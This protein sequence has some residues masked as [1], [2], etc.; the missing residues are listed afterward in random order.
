MLDERKAAILRAVV[1]EY[2]ETA[3]PVG[4]GAVAKATALTV[5]PATVRNDMA[6]LEADGYLHQPH[7]SA[8]RV[9]T[10][11]G[12]RYFV[13]SV[14]EAALGRPDNRQVMQFFTDMRGEIEDLMRETAGLLS[15]LTDYA[16]VVV[17]HS[18]DAASVRSFQLVS[19]T[20][21]V[22]LAVV[23]LS[24]G[25]VD[26]HTVE[27]SGFTAESDLT[28]ADLT[29]VAATVSASLINNP[30]HQ[31]GDLRSTNTRRLDELAALVLER[32]SGVEVDADRVY[33]DGTS[34]FIN[35]FDAVDPVSQVLTIL[36]QQL[37]VVS[38]ITDVLDRGLTVAIGSETGLEPLES[39]SVV[40][41]PYEIDGEEAG[42][43]AVLG[44]TRMNYPQAMAAVAVV[45]REL[46]ERLS[47]G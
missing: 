13:D 45:S 5:S 47:D 18:S 44:P 23:V 20:P 11:L 10:D 26:K 15:R 38:L 14:G 8:G 6:N 2:I 39:C 31:P 28:E 19:L 22:A 9:P 27:L 30:L 1:Q 7:T 17:D 46:G 37:V 35:A 24:N 29:Q 43:I 42:S 33:V 32:T 40:V 21:D 41:S 16:A 34:R 4:S 36:E 12:Y 3:Q 25:V